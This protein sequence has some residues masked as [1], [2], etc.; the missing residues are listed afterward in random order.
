MG[1]ASADDVSPPLCDQT[2]SAFVQAKDLKAGG[3]LQAPT[4][5]AE[6]TGVRL[7]HAHTTTYD[8]TIG[9]LH[10]YYVE[11]GDTPVLVHNN[12]VECPRTPEELKRDAEALHDA[13]I[14]NPQ[15]PPTI[16]NKKADQG[17]T[18]ATGQ[19][20]GRSVY[21]VSN[22]ATTPE[23]RALAEKLG[24]ERINGAE[25]IVPGLQTDAEQIMLNAVEDGTLS[26]EGMMAASRPFCDPNR[27]DCA[28][29]VAGFPK[30][31]GFEQARIPPWER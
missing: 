16:G 7:G 10:T 22:N 19:L 18:V 30:I 3:V 2:Q 4:G 23:M 8:L 9:T 27:Q 15:K 17:I 1:R 13:G 12:N 26:D 31:Q 24:Y 29:R 21:T 11:A 28:A 25:H 14:R 6:V 5:N 20:G